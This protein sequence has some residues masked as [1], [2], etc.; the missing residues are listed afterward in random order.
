M[1]PSLMNA[2]PNDSTVIKYFAALALLEMILIPLIS[3]SRLVVKFRQD[4][5]CAD[6]I[7]SYLALPKHCDQR[8]GITETAIFGEDEL[9][10][11]HWDSKK[12]AVELFDANVSADANSAPVL[13]EL[14]IR[15]PRGQ[16]TLL[17]GPP[18]SGKSLFVH[19]VLGE[20]HIGSGTLCVD[21]ESID[22]CDESSLIRNT[23]LRYSIVGTNPFNSYRYRQV[24]TACLLDADFD[25]M[26]RKDNSLAGKDGANLSIDQKAR[27][28]IARTIYSRPSTAIFDNIFAHV[29]PEK[30]QIIFRNL[31][32]FEGLLQQQGTTVLLVADDMDYVHTTEHILIFDGK[33]SVVKKNMAGALK[34][35]TVKRLQRP[36]S[37]GSTAQQ[38][39]K[40]E[41]DPDDDAIR[42]QEEG[43]RREAETS[44]CP[45]PPK[46]GDLSLYDYYLSSLSWFDIASC[47]IGVVLVSVLELAPCTSKLPLPLCTHSPF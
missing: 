5:E 18:K 32:S 8:R 2:T 33:G 45:V 16:V 40:S 43:K 37:I 42:G 21:K 38:D 41:V 28:R 34:D 30:A 26:P 6:R 31:F 7:Q 1:G 29:T 27:L 19:S 11:Y 20:T 17:V 14:N 3:L 25:R 13:R 9:D 4:V 22:L 44:V 15:V 12:F 35:P 10:L 36:G 47:I 46:Y 24:I 39:L 23:T